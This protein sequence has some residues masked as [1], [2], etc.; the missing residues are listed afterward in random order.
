MIEVQSLQKKYGDVLAVDGVSFRAEPG[1][2][3]GLLGPNGAGKTTT[4]GC[5]SGLL[6][7]SSGV[8]K[9]LGYDLAMDGRR[10]RC[11]MGVVPQELALY[12]DLSAL[13]NLSFWG[14]AYGLRGLDLK[15]RRREILAATGLLDRAGEKV[16]QFSGGMKRRLNLAC[17]MMHH[18]KVL[19]L[20]EPTAGVDPQSRAR[21]LD[22][23]REEARQGACVL[24]TTH[25]MEEAEN[26]CDQLAIMDKG[27]VI[28]GGS[29]ADLRLQAGEKD[30]LRLQ[31]VF[32]PLKVTEAL[33]GLD[34]VEVVQADEQ[35]VR[36]VLRDASRK[37]PLLFQALAQA[38]AEVRE[39]KMTQP[40]LES[41]FIKLTGKELRE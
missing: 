14:G 6:Q 2:I 15:R 33:R 21:L 19:L 26:L 31:G 22:L 37:L 13:E 28:A 5:I 36:L 35:G 4:L 30:V 39:T 25:Y 40:N 20:D 34:E 27:K 24:Y 1:R 8:I 41:L 10:A 9:V 32:N 7:P 3:F 11:Q 16:S 23:I 12:E 38:G 17:A 29:L 18:P